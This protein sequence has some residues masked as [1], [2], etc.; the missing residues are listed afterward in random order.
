M[1]N[2]GLAPGTSAKDLVAVL[3]SVAGHTASISSGHDRDILAGYLKWAEDAIWTLASRVDQETLNRLVQTP[4]YWSLRAMNGSEA[5]VR[6]Q[7]F[8]EVERRRS[9]L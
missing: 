4:H 6:G 8:A 1:W 2:V 3:Q 9:D 5:H 7:V